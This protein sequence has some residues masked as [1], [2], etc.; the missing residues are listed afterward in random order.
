MKRERRNSLILKTE[1][2]EKEEEVEARTRRFLARDR[3]LR[4]Y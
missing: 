3:Q 2:D 4:C 1:G